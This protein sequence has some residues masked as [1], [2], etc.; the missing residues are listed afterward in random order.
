M[1]SI[2]RLWDSLL[3]II[4]TCAAVWWL[5]H[6]VAK[7]ITSELIAFFSIQSAVILPAM[8]FTA[9]ILKPDG[10]ELSEARR[11]HSALKAQMSFWVTLLGMDFI[12]VFSLIAGKAMDWKLV[13]TLPSDFGRVDLGW[14]FLATLCFAGILAVLRT[15]PFVRGVMSLLELNS[16]M[17]EKAI[18]RRNREEIVEYKSLHPPKPVELPEGYGNVRDRSEDASPTPPTAR[19]RP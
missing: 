12:A 7:A 10:L 13:L 19:H 14:V 15:I 2:A 11:Y 1:D 18:G 3:A 17:T 6:D 4:I 9:G 5:S 8:I 16:E